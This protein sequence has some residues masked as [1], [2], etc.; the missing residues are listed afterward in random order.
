[1]TCSKCQ[2]V[3]LELE[4]QIAS[5][6]NFT[7]TLTTIS[8]HLYGRSSTVWVVNRSKALLECH[9]I[10]L[11][12]WSMCWEHICFT[13]NVFLSMP[14]ATDGLKPF[15][16][17]WIFQH[18]GMLFIIHYGK[19]RNSQ[20]L[21]VINYQPAV[22]NVKDLPHISNQSVWRKLWHFGFRQMCA[23]VVMCL[24]FK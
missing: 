3:R 22:Q 19:V 1:M 21:S 12:L 10:T 7:L 20:K 9:M 23:N 17:F 15:I 2:M 13:V 24:T 18:L 5:A 16:F 6:T 8:E 4:S 14:F 11:H